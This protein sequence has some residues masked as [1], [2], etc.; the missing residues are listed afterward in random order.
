MR[1][2]HRHP[3]G[4][5]AGPPAGWVPHDPSITL[6]RRDNTASAGSAQ[7]APSVSIA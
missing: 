7:P 6:G 3:R 2:H 5:G 4:T 1:E